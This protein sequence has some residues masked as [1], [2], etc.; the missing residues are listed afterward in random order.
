VLL[1]HDKALVLPV[2]PSYGQLFGRTPLHYTVKHG[3]ALSWGFC[4][5]SS[6]LAKA[7]LPSSL[8]GDLKDEAGFTTRCFFG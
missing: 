3:N 1:S 7:A 5:L 2:L 6:V 4:L 8:R